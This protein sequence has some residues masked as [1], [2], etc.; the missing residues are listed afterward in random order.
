MIFDNDVLASQ[1]QIL[2]LRMPDERRL[3]SLEIM[4]E[5]PIFADCPLEQQLSRFVLSSPRADRISENELQ[6][7]A[8]AIITRMHQRLAM[9]STDIVFNWLMELAWSS[10]SWLAPFKQRVCPPSPEYGEVWPTCVT[11]AF[12]HIPHIST[13]SATDLSS[14]RDSSGKLSPNWGLY[15]ECKGGGIGS[16][17]A[18]TALERQS[19]YA[20]A[21][22]SPPATNIVPSSHSTVPCIVQNQCS[23]GNDLH[24]MDADI[25]PT[26]QSSGRI[27]AN[28]QLDKMLGES[29]ASVQRGAA[30]HLIHDPNFDKWLGRQLSLWVMVIMSPNNPCCHI[31]SDYEIQHY[32]RC[33]LYNK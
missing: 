16:S 13:L 17:Q 25:S 21:Y 27:P 22:P 18:L 3:R 23:V 5:K 32:A 15:S 29:G 8:C 20:T 2:P 33:L 31:P 19:C 10:T 6:E 7:E 28:R 12:E 9:L 4:R 30:M 24:D 11:S 14:R 26:R 1:A